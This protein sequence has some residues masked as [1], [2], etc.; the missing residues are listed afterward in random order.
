MTDQRPALLVTRR[1]PPN[2]EAR[3]ERDYLA[4]LNRDDRLYDA[5]E[6]VRR[7][8]GMDAMLIAHSERITAD[9][10][11]R[12]PGSIRVI[13][14][15][16][17]GVDHVDLDACRRRGIAVTNT[18]G[19]LADATAEIA[20]LLI[21]GAAR[22]AAEGDR[23]IREGRWN[24]WGPV[25]MLGTQVTGKTL[26]ILGMGR[27]GRVLARRARGFDMR[28][29][30]HNR[31]PL[32]P[33]LAQGATW[34]QTF[35]EMLPQCQ[36]LSIHCPAT[37]QTVGMI[38]ARALS[39]LP[40]GAVVVNVARGSVVVEKDLIAALRSGRIAAGLD[41]FEHEPGI[42]ADFASLDNTFLLPHLGS[43][44]RETRDAMGFLA[45]DNLDA[46]FAGREPPCRVA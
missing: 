14:N 13:A 1:L 43:A 18:P 20:M 21:L 42:D 2:V 8:E 3:I 12:L 37:P 32:E 26:G 22:R 35:E 28:V 9:V 30:Y 46:V 23:L 44:T 31:R 15:F 16:S 5:E 11:A 45:L 7:S 27:V 24:S 25:F 41:V 6:I 34:C 10:A 36:F 29:L 17:V 19:V 40:D 33:E 4:T 38:D 39:L